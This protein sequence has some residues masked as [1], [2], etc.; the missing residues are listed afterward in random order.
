[1]PN[2]QN[3][4]YDIVFGVLKLS[5]RQQIV[6]TFLGIILFFGWTNSKD[7]DETKTLNKQSLDR[8]HEINVLLIQDNRDLKKEL[9]RA[10]NY[11]HD[12]SGHKIS[13]VDSIIIS[14]KK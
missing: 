10:Y 14:K 12:I 6:A 5:E 3:T 7:K 4:I 11:N 13:A 2:N 8:L 1:M 9:I